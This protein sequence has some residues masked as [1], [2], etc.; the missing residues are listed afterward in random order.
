MGRTS[1]GIMTPIDSAD[2]AKIAAMT[3]SEY[4]L[5]YQRRY[6]QANKAKAQEYQRNYNAQ[7]KKKRGG[8]KGSKAFE[9]PRQVIQTTFH[10]SHI[11]QQH[12]PDKIAWIINKILRGERLYAH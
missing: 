10:S 1:K 8:R 3:P 11:M 2:A 7:H 6:Y 12:N 4:R 9:A 5:E